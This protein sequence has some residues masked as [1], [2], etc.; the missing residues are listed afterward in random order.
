MVSAAAGRLFAK[1]I[2]RLFP[3]G[4]IYLLCRSTVNNEG[5]LSPAGLAS[6]VQR[7][8][9]VFRAPRASEFLT[10]VNPTAPRRAKPSSLR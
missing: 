4:V 8:P 5:R 10:S 3:T 2:L 9:V 7:N 1:V 6:V